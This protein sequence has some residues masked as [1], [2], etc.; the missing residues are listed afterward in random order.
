[1]A[2][3]AWRLL[4]LLLLL[5]LPLLVE[6]CFLCLLLF[7]S[8]WCFLSFLLFLEADGAITSTCQNLLPNLGFDKRAAVIHDYW[9]KLVR[10]CPEISGLF[11]IGGR[12]IGKI[13]ERVYPN[14]R[15]VDPGRSPDG[16]PTPHK[17][18]IKALGRRRMLQS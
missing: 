6:L 13:E 17:Q 15:G 7:L 16:A 1:M 5:L 12:Q 18:K 8:F 2:A 4:L 9:K 14:T 10:Q 3:A 11:W